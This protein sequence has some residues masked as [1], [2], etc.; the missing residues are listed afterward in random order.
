MSK[1]S[2][3]VVASL[4]LL[5][6]M[7]SLS[8]SFLSPPSALLHI[9]HHHSS[10]SSVSSSSLSSPLTV[11]R[12][13]S[14]S[15]SLTFS[16][17]SSSSSSSSSPLGFRSLSPSPTCLNAKGKDAKKPKG[18]VK[19]GGKDAGGSAPSKSVAAA[20][21]AAPKT[22]SGANKSG[23]K[24]RAFGL[25]SFF[26]S[27]AATLM[28]GNRQVAEPVGRGIVMK[29]GWGIN[30]LAWIRSK[31]GGAKPVQQAAK[32]HVGEKIAMYLRKAGLSDWK[33]LCL[34][35]G[36]PVVELRGAIPLGVWM[37]SM[38]LPKI[39]LLSVLG[40][41]API[42]FLLLALR[43]SVVS[44]LFGPLLRRARTKIPPS[45]MGPTSAF[46][47]YSSLAFFVAIP[48]PGTGAW[49]AALIAHVLNLPLLPSLAAISAGVVGAGAIVGGLA[50]FGKK[51]GLA[52]LAIVAAWALYGVV[53]GGGKKTAGTAK[54]G[55][56]KK[57]GTGGGGNG[58]GRGYQWAI[59]AVRT[60]QKSS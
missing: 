9:G 45:M 15:A 55:V 51:G 42:P 4:L 39:L 44:A 18:G 36:M 5:L 37:K 60:A 49:T 53:S 48:L 17:S 43:S 47:V 59:E 7:L 20:T 12:R 11:G 27:A 28:G 14:S 35:A 57:G 41:I 38:P 24:G 31:T 32:L 8:S 25:L 29:T 16:F 30:S 54:G 3:R 26:S 22:G 52:A 56:G 33:I 23:G 21:K 58:A 19:G 10:S 50:K 13:F 40:N 1:N 34:V 6:S 2:L 46:S